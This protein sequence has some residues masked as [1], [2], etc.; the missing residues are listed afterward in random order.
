MAR[1]CVSIPHM[2]NGVSQQAS[3]MRL[4]TQGEE[5]INFYPSIVKGLIKRPPL[6][7]VWY[8][9]HHHSPNPL[10]PG[11]FHLIDRG[12]DAT[13]RQRCF[14][15]VDE[16]SINILGTDGY[17]I[18]CSATEQAMNYLKGC[19][20]KYDIVTIA[21]YTFIINPKIRT[22]LL[23][24]EKTPDIPEQAL[25]Y[26]K[27]ASYNSYYRIEVF[28]AHKE[29]SDIT[30][31]FFDPIVGLTTTPSNVGTVD[32]PPPNIST[33]GIASSLSSNIN[34]DVEKIYS[35]LSLP[36]PMVRAFARDSVV[37]ITAADGY[38]I[39][40]VTVTDTNGNA[41]MTSVHKTVK[42][43][44]DLPNTA[45]DGMVVKVTGDDVSKLNDY[46]VKYERADGT[47]DVA[48]R[49]GVWRE[50]PGPGVA[51]KLDPS[52]MPH[53]LVNKGDHFTFGPCE[54]WGERVCGDDATAPNPEF[55]GSPIT[56]LF[57]YRNRL[58]LLSE[59]I[60][61]LSAASEFFTFFPATVTTT[62]DSDPIT[63]SASIEGAPLLKHAVTLN[64]ETI[65]FSDRTQF[66][67]VSPD[68][69][70]PET[71]AINVVTHYPLNS[72]IKPI[73]NG[74]NLFFVNASE[75]ASRVYEYSVDAETSIKTAVD[76]TAHVPRYIPPDVDL[77][78]CSPELNL[79]VLGS[80]TKDT[81]DL[82]C[83]K[84]Y[85]SGSDK[86][87]SAWFRFTLS[88]CQRVRGLAF[89]NNV[90]YAAVQ[91]AEDNEGM[92]R[93]V[94]MKMDFSDAEDAPADFGSHAI[95]F[96][97]HLDVLLPTTLSG[98]Y[99]SDTNET[100][101]SL[102]S[103]ALTEELQC[104]NLNTFRD[105]PIKRR[106]VDAQ[107]SV[108]AVFNGD[109]RTTRVLFGIPYK[110]R[111]TFSQQYVRDSSGRSA[112][113][114]TGTSVHHGR[115]MFQKWRLVL[116]QTGYVAASVRHTD[117]GA[118]FRYPYE[119][120]KYNTTGHS[121]GVTDWE[122]STFTFPCRGGAPRTVIT[123]ENDTWLPSRILSAEWEA[124]F[125]TK[126]VTKL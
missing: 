74:N 102:P 67:L 110:A 100:T 12:G 24:D 79:L 98:T 93:V 109:V 35:H 112:G 111:Y 95:H 53:A 25:V 1:V 92:T 94:L 58:G 11:S 41:F 77:M 121:L 125:T 120:I 78:A 30:Q 69:L 13:N 88:G 113:G 38:V 103:K 97:P 2:F 23:P 27:Q 71:A 57:Q 76:I 40:A 63:L 73:S 56:G 21:D 122:E 106:S 36:G 81:S 55:I 52:T 42:R 83:Y 14:L 51:T 5:Q 85:W 16:D 26:V 75:L 54:N 44:S 7:P 68:V 104:V 32:N 116:G 47:P 45:F 59:D 3:A 101:C 117:T 115:V 43:F 87:Q 8:L 108:L 46:Y 33:A 105:L 118:S 34:H 19:G 80:S 126:G 114:G 22:A 39:E 17:A 9:K 49:A 48:P 107:G 90:L 89:I 70:S 62:R 37:F 86:L 123:L 96:T 28:I 6:Q 18:P 20:G 91:Q 65:L 31:L 29:N 10:K 119:N 72:D 66:R 50:C 84:Y 61:A 4:P 60:V 15:Y 82:W 64:E 99:N 124:D